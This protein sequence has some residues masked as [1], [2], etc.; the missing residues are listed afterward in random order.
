MRRL[1]P[2]KSWLVLLHK[3]RCR[4]TPSTSKEL[5][6][7]GHRPLERPL[8]SHLPT[9]FDAPDLDPF[10]FAEVGETWPRADSKAKAQRSNHRTCESRCG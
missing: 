3:T 10:G 5:G 6:S 2:A 1:E 4:L 9:S 8:G 7:A